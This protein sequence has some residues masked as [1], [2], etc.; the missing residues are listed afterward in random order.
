MTAAELAQ[1]IGVPEGAVNDAAE[2]CAR[3]LAEWFGSAEAA[4]DA[5]RDNPAEMVGIA[6][7]DH[8]K[9]TKRMAAAAHKQPVRTAQA[10][11]E[12]I[13]SGAAH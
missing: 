13:N 5:L 1:Q 12:M 2:A 9:T 8:V 7:A 4:A 10:V 11:L 3:R 6:L